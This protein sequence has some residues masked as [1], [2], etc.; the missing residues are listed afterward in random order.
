VAGGC[1]VGKPRTR[2]GPAAPGRTAA[3]LQ[4]GGDI[5]AWAKTA[6]SRLVSV[7]TSGVS[8]VEQYETAAQGRGH[9]P[10]NLPPGTTTNALLASAAS[11]LREDQIGRLRQIHQS[12]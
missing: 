3:S 9:N 10:E 5:R 6:A 11:G 12:G 1:L 7:G 8:A 2:A 4:R